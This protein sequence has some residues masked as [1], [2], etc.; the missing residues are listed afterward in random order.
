MY[1][2]TIGKDMI[3]EIELQKKINSYNYIINCI[4]KKNNVNIER[5]DKDKVAIA[6]YAYDKVVLSCENTDGS[7]LSTE[8]HFDDYYNTNDAYL[9]IKFVSPELHVK[10]TK[11]FAD[12]L[13]LA[14]ASFAHC[15]KDEKSILVEF[16][17][18]VEGE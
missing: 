1:P 5:I 11:N 2:E 10:D 4:S 18:R 14:D 9:I 3:K 8:L 13:F 15:Y 16:D 12:V 7:T 17:F 6:C